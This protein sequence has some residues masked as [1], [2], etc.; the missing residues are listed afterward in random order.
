MEEKQL[1]AIEKSIKSGANT[2]Q[3]IFLDTKIDYDK[4]IEWFSA[5]KE[6]VDRLS[7]QPVRKAEAKVFEDGKETTAGARWLLTHHP[8]AK[9]EWSEKIDQK[10]EH[11]G[12][13]TIEWA[14]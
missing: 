14:E 12:G 10:T 7:Y 13:I 8:V 9:K 3:K 11:S 1:E 6:H 4:L 5:N 2:I